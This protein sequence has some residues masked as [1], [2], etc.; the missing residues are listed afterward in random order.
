M[1]WWSY[2]QMLTVSPSYRTSV[3]K[4]TDGL[5]DSYRCVSLV[6]EYFCVSRE[7]FPSCVFREGFPSCVLCFQAER[8]FYVPSFVIGNT[9]VPSFLTGNTKD[10]VTG[11]LSFVSSSFTPG[12]S[13]CLVSPDWGTLLVWCLRTEEHPRTR[14]MFLWCLVP[15]MSRNI[16]QGRVCV[17][18]RVLCPHVGEHSEGVFP[19]FC[20]LCLPETLG[21]LYRVLVGRMTGYCR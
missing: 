18:P 8:H 10:W 4:C 19:S 20:L 16:L 21:F 7:C 11:C 9:C 2:G 5:M 17:L 14:C 15:L 12:S 6:E 3:H 1:S 13:S